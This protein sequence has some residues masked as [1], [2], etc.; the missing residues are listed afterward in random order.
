M[1]L[2]YTDNTNQGTNVLAYFSVSSLTIKNVYSIDTSRRRNGGASTLALMTFI[3]SP[4]PDP[5][6]NN[7]FIYLSNKGITN[8]SSLVCIVIFHY[9]IVFLSKIGYCVFRSQLAMGQTQVRA[10]MDLLL[11]Q[12]RAKI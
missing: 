6:F 2:Y 5:P 11:G 1:L 7:H 8:V 3:L 10:L 9:G 4:S 12:R